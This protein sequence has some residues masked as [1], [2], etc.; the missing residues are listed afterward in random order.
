MNKPVDTSD[1]S[2]TVYPSRLR[3]SK[4][5]T[6]VSPSVSLEKKRID[7]LFFAMMVLASWEH[8]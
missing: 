3:C 5:S 2:S 1:T 8:S 7:S 6:M 4:V